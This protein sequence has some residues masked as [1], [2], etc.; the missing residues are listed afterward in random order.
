MQVLDNPALSQYFDSFWR[1]G[2]VRRGGGN[3]Y[4]HEQVVYQIDLACVTTIEMGTL[5][6]ESAGR[7][8]RRV[9]SSIT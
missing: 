3:G 8:L 9:L 6:L 5:G 1:G 2:G 7:P 4:R